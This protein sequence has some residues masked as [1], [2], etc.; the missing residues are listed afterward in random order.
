MNKKIDPAYF[1]GIIKPGE[2]YILTFEQDR[3]GDPGPIE[4]IY[5]IGCPDEIP[6]AIEMEMG[7]VLIDLYEYREFLGVKMES[8]NCFRLMLL[9]YD[10]EE[11]KE[12]H[13]E[14]YLHRIHTFGEMLIN[15]KLRFGVA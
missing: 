3:E 10:K 4:Y 12:I 2:V 7:I 1:A 9:C 6:P 14:F 13:Y 5:T 8:E 15:I 11:E